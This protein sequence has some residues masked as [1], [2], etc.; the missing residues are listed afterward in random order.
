MQKPLEILKNV[1]RFSS[2]KPPQEAI[3][4][5][6]ING[7]D[8]LAL[9]PT[10]GGK[11]I[12]FQVPALSKKGICIVISPLV[13][14]MKDQ[15]ENLKSKGIKAIALT[16]GLKY[17]EV[18]SLL[19]NCIYGNYK[20]LYISPE[21]LHQ[22]LVQDRIK[23]MDV[24][25]IA[26]DEAHCISQWGNDFRPAY[27]K[28]SILKTFFPKIPLIALTAS[29]TPK[30]IDDIIINLGIEKD[31]IIKKSFSRP[32]IAYIVLEEE[33]KIYR[34]KRLLDE[35][36][37]TA[38][39]YVRNRK[40]TVDIATIINNHGVSA[41]YYHGGI[42]PLE[43][44][45]RLNN[46]LDNKVR[47]MV[48]TNAFGMGIDKADVRMVIHIHLPDSMESYYQEAGRAGRNGEKAFAILL[49]N[50]SD[51]L[52]VKNQFLK[53][54]PDVPFIRLLY[55]RLN[56]YFQI[57]YGEGVAFSTHFK[58]N[59]FCKVY[60][61]NPL[62]TYNGLKLLDRHSIISLS[63]NFNQ[64]AT[65]QFIVT[66]HQLF[67][68]LDTNNKLEHVTQ[69][70]LRTYGGI[71]DSE[72]SINIPLIAT[73]TSSSEK[74]IEAVLNT[75]ANDNI[76]VYNAGNRDTE[77][78]FL[79]PREDEKT[80]NVIAREVK[81]QNSYKEQ[82][83]NAVIAYTTNDTLCK[84]IQLLTYFGE[85]NTVACGICSVCNSEKEPFVKKE[86]KKLCQNIIVLLSSTPKTSKELTEEL[87]YK[88]KNIIAALQLL[89]EHNTIT[90]NDKNEYTIIKS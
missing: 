58:F 47:V 24:N 10:G 27:K 85:K 35:H 14:L 5:D 40:A 26:I 50:K 81:Q 2:F 72:V 53:T 1:W 67:K 41:T 64:R 63:E 22:E 43:K 77:I 39:I 73:R 8:V 28:C 36:Q 49:K 23:Q 19:D 42:S 25:L 12:C 30:V 44:G 76:V 62:L 56:N 15:V 88:E 31:K 84:S 9:L 89:L 82:L 61:L 68:Y 33:D 17:T 54:L 7:K 70:L 51:E 37:G 18:D 3:I 66:N 79:I 20:F 4:D 60:K 75:L 71:F 65:I 55:K 6:I 11:S 86:M 13:A 46:W 57:P 59:E 80:I 83:I 90:I 32:N 69:A 45:K 78:T 87:V 48:A 21:R 52:H 29:A 16:G 38:I 34:I 74:E